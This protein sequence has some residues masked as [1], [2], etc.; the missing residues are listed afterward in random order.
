MDDTG[1]RIKDLKPSF[2]ISVYGIYTRPI[3]LWPN[4]FQPDLKELH[5]LQKPK[6]I[7]FKYGYGTLNKTYHLII[8]HKNK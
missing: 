8:A 5:I 4:M 6:E 3:A 7:P 2:E 1:P